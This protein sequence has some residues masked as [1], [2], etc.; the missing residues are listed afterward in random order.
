MDTT[1]FAA[2]LGIVATGLAGIAKAILVGLGRVAKSFDTMGGKLDSLGARFDAM[3]EKHA[4]QEKALI[5]LESTVDE[6]RADTAQSLTAVREARDVVIERVPHRRSG[7][8]PITPP[9]TG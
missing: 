6:G 5:R 4:S 8:R 2:L 3:A 1:Q 9:P 7:S